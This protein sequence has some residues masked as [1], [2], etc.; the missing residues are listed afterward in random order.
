MNVRANHDYRVIRA[1]TFYGN[2]TGEIQGIRCA[3]CQ[4]SIGRLQVRGGRS[5]LARY[6]RMR[7]IIVKHLHS[8][9][10]ALIQAQA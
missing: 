3:Y 4:F 6:N 2:Q 9:H 10:G 5:G 7:A 1:N 8:E